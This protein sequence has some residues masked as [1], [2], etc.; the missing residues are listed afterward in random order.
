MLSPPISIRLMSVALNLRVSPGLASLHPL[1]GFIFC[2]RGT[3][4]RIVVLAAIYLPFHLAGLQF[5]ATIISIYE[6]HI[7]VEVFLS[8][9]LNGKERA[10]AHCEQEA[11]ESSLIAAPTASDRSRSPPDR[12]GKGT[13]KA[14]SVRQL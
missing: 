6:N 11:A 7:R 10:A 2:P 13:G 5:S 8:F 1:P 12:H 9:W 14:A 4:D 3:F